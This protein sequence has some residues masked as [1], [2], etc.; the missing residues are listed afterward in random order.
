MASSQGPAS[1][2]AQATV[3]GSLLKSRLI[4]NRWLGQVSRKKRE[5]E[6]KMFKMNE[7]SM[8]PYSEYS[9]GPGQLNTAAKTI[10]ADRDY[11]GSLNT[12]SNRDRRP[13]SYSPEPAGDANYTDAKSKE[14][15]RQTT[16]DI[17]I[18]EHS[19]FEH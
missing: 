14:E 10:S 12:G 13:T 4:T 17:R 7:I 15:E 2:I 5:L 16:M 8:M 11:H 3:E 9:V 1:R 6:E 19:L 18:H